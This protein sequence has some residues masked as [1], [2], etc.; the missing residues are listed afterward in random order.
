MSATGG[1]AVLGAGS[2]GT[3]LA[4]Q[5]ARSGRP[6]LLWGRDADPLNV[7]GRARENAVYLPGCPFPDSLDVEPDLATALQTSDDV[8][9]VVPSHGLRDTCKAVAATGHVPA[10]ISWA[11]KGLEPDTGKLAH[12]VV[13]EVLGER[14]M[15][16]LSGPTFAKEVGAGL[17][18]AITVAGDAD[19]ADFIA[20]ALHGERFRAYTS[21]DIVGVEIGGAAKNVI[22]IGAGMSDGLG[23]GANSRV[24]LITRG[25]AE[26]SRLAQALGADPKTLMGLAGMGDLVLTCTDDQSRNRRMGLALAAGK[27]QQEAHKEIFQVVEGVSAAREVHNLAQR[28]D[29]DMPITEQIYRV[30]HEG[31]SPQQ[32]VKDLFE[33]D[34]K[35]ESE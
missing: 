22:A 3:A 26:I 35:D 13:T 10:R 30:L 9:I 32:A 27:S 34:R 19:Y 17:P 29:V 20:D 24:A 31:V 14:P 2:W 5:L 23:F 7:I 18:T 16:V 8:L 21:H 1:I 6:V 15:A 25:L 4:I 12:E 33:R 28:L 11:T